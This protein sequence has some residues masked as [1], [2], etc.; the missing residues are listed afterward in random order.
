MANTIKTTT[1]TTNKGDVM[2]EKIELRDYINIF[3]KRRKTILTM[4]IV[5][6]LISAGLSF[7]V[8]DPVYESSTL[9]MVKRQTTGQETYY[10]YD[11]IIISKMLVNTY[12]K[13]IQSKT[14][15]SK[16]ISNLNL[17]MG[18][19]EFR[20]LI[21]VN[22]L[23][24]TEMMEIVVENK[25]PEKAAMIANNIAFVFAQEVS[26]IMAIQNITVIDVAD[27]PTEPAKPN[28]ILI[29]AAATLLGLIGGLFTAFLREYLDDTIKTPNDVEKYLGI[30]LMGVIPFDGETQKKQKWHISARG[31]P[32]ENET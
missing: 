15:L 11:D 27:I 9:L 4:T 3:Y 18:V 25:D 19:G 30:Q 12:E 28:R 29:I 26:R 1:T 2:H 13:I 22:L 32:E 8:L 23:E 24:E 31:V 5:A 20:K 6:I 10:R 17:N 16:V 14:V 7:F 21:T